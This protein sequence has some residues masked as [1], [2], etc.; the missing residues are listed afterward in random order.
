MRYMISQA[1]IQQ[2]EVSFPPFYQRKVESGIQKAADAWQSGT[3]HFTAAIQLEKS[4]V[5]NIYALLAMQRQSILRFQSQFLDMYL[6]SRSRTVLVARLAEFL[7][8]AIYQ[9]AETDDIFQAIQLLSVQKLPHY[10]ITHA[11]LTNSLK[12]LQWYLNNTRPEL[13][14]LKQD[15][16]F[17]FH[18]GKFN[19]F[20]HN[21]H[22]LIILKVPLTLHEL[23]KTLDVFE[24]QKIPLLSPNSV[25]HY[26]IR[27][28]D[29]DVI[30]YH[31]DVDYYFT[32][33]N[34]S[35][36]TMDVLDLGTTSVILRRRSVPTCALKLIEGNLQ[37]IKDHSSYHVIIGPVPRG[38][39]K[40]TEKALLFSNS[41]LPK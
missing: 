34:L 31:R 19:A 12:C 23:T 10:F 26:T 36:V 29:F 41:A 21:R 11:T 3:L 1:E 7:A 33:P 25:D 14:I 4:R 15:A 37:Q 18:H 6:E 17:Y 20:R 35:D 16:K 27:T 5:D 40:L 8:S 39:Y 13:T 32:V 28:T 9:V 22:L 2:R 24:L 30:G 38:V